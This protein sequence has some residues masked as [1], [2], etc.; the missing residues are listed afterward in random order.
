[1]GV[2]YPSLARP[3]EENVGRFV[4]ASRAQVGIAKR[5]TGGAAPSCFLLRLVF[6][7]L[8]LSANSFRVKS[9]VDAVVG[10][11]RGQCEFFMAVFLESDCIYMM[12]HFLVTVSVCGS[13]SS[14][15]CI[16]E[17]HLISLL[18][19]GRVRRGYAQSFR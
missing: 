10:G 14:D 5:Q 9:N 11:R 15:C 18:G 4:V 2:V 6:S 17:F 8:L 13:M 19:L 16:V 12:F 1:M 3:C 7:C